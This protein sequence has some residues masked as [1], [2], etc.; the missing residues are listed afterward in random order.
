MEKQE[1]INQ[2]YKKFN[3]E[4]DKHFSVKQLAEYLDMDKG[5]QFKFVVQALTQMEHDD[6][7]GFDEDNH[8]F[9]K[10]EM[11]HFDGEF[12]ANDRGFGFVTVDPEE[13]DFFIKFFI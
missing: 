10:Q 4:P 5:A 9:L 3:E 1:I 12:H 7:V 13:P 2:L 6:Q 8:Y 11:P